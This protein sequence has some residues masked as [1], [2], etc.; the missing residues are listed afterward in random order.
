MVPGQIRLM[1]EASNVSDEPD[2]QARM[3]VFLDGIHAADGV[4]E[5]VQWQDAAAYAWASLM[6]DDTPR[7]MDSDPL[8]LAL[9]AAALDAWP[10]P[11]CLMIVTDASSEDA[12]LGLRELRAIMHGDACILESAF[13]TASARLA[14][15]ADVNVRRVERALG[16][17]E[18]L[19][20]DVGTDRSIQTAS[21][22]YCS[23]VCG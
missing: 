17:L 3:T 20:G 7:V 18:P 15:L 22:I 2:T 16:V 21:L 8:M 23:L 19:T 9:V 12:P 10:M 5:T 6:Q 13:T 1:A 14:G 4:E 11:A